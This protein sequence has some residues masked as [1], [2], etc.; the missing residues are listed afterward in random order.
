MELV[1]VQINGNWLLGI[2]QK[3]LL[4]HIYPNQSAKYLRILCN[5]WH[6]LQLSSDSQIQFWHI[7]NLDIT[8]V[9]EWKS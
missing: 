6:N 4:K 7:N 2:F 8:S 5:T 9:I 1:K 3:Y